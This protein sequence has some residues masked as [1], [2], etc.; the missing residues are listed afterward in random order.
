MTRFS[1]PEVTFAE[2]SAQQ[3]EAEIVGRF[4]QEM[5]VKLAQ[6]DPRRKFIQAIVALLAQQR[7]LIDYSA[8]QN[9]L[10]YASGPF[11]DHLGADNDTPR[12]KPTYAKTTVR[13]H[14]TVLLPQIIRTGTRVTAGDGVYFA[15]TKEVFVKSG[16]SYVDA[17]VQCTV[18]GKI[19][20]G[21]L[22]GQLKQL[23]DPL[24]W[25]QSV[26]N[27]TKSEGGADE[28]EDDPYA[29]R[30]HQAPERFSVAGPEGAYV[31]WARTASPLIVDV[32]VL[33][34]SPG[35]VEIRPLLEGG[36]IPEQEILDLVYA[37]CN[38]RKVRPLTDKVEV[39][40]PEAIFY[41]LTVH[42]WIS[43]SHST[44]A[45][46]VQTRVDQAVLDYLQ[47]QKSKQ[48]R[49]IDPSELVARMKNAGAKRVDV[50]LPVYQKIEPYQVAQD[51]LV[52]IE[53]RGLEH[54]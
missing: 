38:E 26:E 49:D 1:L 37:A 34:P 51:K 25:V 4:E 53:Y 12:L 40:A 10:G 19:G 41:D 43:A 3:I 20:N 14:L 36:V 27:L 32:S 22:P 2:K 17:E 18:P 16:Q 6:A 24:P 39:A 30:I 50:A 5:G 31:Y 33:S 11:L 52:R 44:I 21:Y 42:Y 29:E 48:G 35:V 28:E 46:Q 13:F 23:V 15:T 7:S 47:W 8:K 45:T 9:L 54:D